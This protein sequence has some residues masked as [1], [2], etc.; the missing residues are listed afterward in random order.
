MWSHLPRQGRR[1]VP[2]P[3]GC[4]CQDDFAATYNRAPARV[5]PS[6]VHL[7]LSYQANIASL[8]Q[9][10][11]YNV[12][13]PLAVFRSG[14]RQLS[15]SDALLVWQLALERSDDVWVGFLDLAEDTISPLGR[16]HVPRRNCIYNGRLLAH[17]TRA[18]SF[19]YGSAKQRALLIW[20][21]LQ[22]EGLY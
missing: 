5:P 20:R 2:F 18:G 21:M 9:F 12:F 1:H 7:S 14:I 16:E 4:S 6:Y 17:T 19:L 8:A 22:P 10:A 3:F 11:S 15:G 13:N